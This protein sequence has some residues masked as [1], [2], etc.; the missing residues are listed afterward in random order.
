M[1]VQL[2][3]GLPKSSCYK[4]IRGTPF[5]PSRQAFGDRQVACVVQCR[6]PF[7]MLMKPNVTKTRRTN[8]IH[9]NTTGVCFFYL[10]VEN[11]VGIVGIPKVSSAFLSSDSFGWDCFG[12]D[13]NVLQTIDPTCSRC[14]KRLFQ[15]K[16][17]AFHSS[18]FRAGLH[19]LIVA[20]MF[21]SCCLIILP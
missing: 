3:P 11:K 15:T 8:Q 9:P 21:V 12:V 20:R 1:L 19:L 14:V 10:F 6:G 18:R 5:W 17:N 4:D 7:G 16:I 13:F 2:L